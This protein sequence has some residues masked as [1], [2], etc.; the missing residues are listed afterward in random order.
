VGAGD[1]VLGA[2][3]GAIVFWIL[4]PAL[5]HALRVTELQVAFSEDPAHAL[6]SAADSSCASRFT[7]FAALGFVPV[8]TQDEWC[9]FFNPLRWRW[10]A[11]APQLWMAH[12]SGYDFATLHR[13]TPEEPVRFSVVTFLS[14]GGRV[15]T[16][17]PGTGLPSPV[18]PGSLRTELTRVEPA[19][20]CAKHERQLDDFCDSEKARPRR[21]RSPRPRRSR[22]RS[23][24]A[25]LRALDQTN[26]YLFI[27][28]SFIAPARIGF[29]A[30]GYLVTHRF[31]GRTAC[32]GICAGGVMFAWMR[33]VVFPAAL[34]DAKIKS[35]ERRSG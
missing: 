29:G 28:V 20:L 15:R 10:R 9:W 25:Q 17:C 11:L 16:T 22:L 7:Q 24:A 13:L 2:F 26:S 21:S 31:D 32:L 4:V 18:Q 23:I 5:M 30:I 1:L 8:G 35:H 6:P 19:D 34:R 33:Y 27:L 3:S 12:P 14:N